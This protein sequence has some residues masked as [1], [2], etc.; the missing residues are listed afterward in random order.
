MKVGEEGRDEE[1][2][3]GGRVPG[4]PRAKDPFRCPSGPVGCRRR[5]KQPEVSATRALSLAS[6]SP[7]AATGP[8]RWVLS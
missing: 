3:R 7:T 5:C 6:L 8:K 2:V 1:E 4:N